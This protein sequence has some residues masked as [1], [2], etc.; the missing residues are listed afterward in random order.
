MRKILVIGYGFAVIT[1]LIIYLSSMP[2]NTIDEVYLSV[3]APFGMSWDELPETHS[4]VVE[5]DCPELI[6]SLGALLTAEQKD[7]ALLQCLN[8]DYSNL[9]LPRADI[10]A[11]FKEGDITMDL[12]GGKKPTQY[13][14]HF[15]HEWRPDKSGRKRKLRQARA[16]KIKAQLIQRYGLPNTNG[17]FDQSTQSG[18]VAGGKIE[19]PCSFWLIN[20]IGILLCSERVVMIDGIEMSLSFINFDKDLIG[21]DSRNRLLIAAGK[22]PEPYTPGSDL[23]NIAPPVKG[24]LKR[25]GKLVYSD[26]LN[27]CHKSGLEPI[28]D[29][30]TRTE[31][32]H[33]VFDDIYALYSGDELADYVFENSLA[34]QTIFPDLDPDIAIMLLLKQAAGQGS[35]SAMNEIG[36]ALLYCYQGIQQDIDGA[37]EWLNMAS[38]LGEPTAKHSL[39]RLHLAGLMGPESSKSEALTLIEQCSTI[40]PGDCAADARTLKEFLNK[41]TDF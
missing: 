30:W 32:F 11:A 38:E 22:M 20:N 14:Y 12:M 10:P 17:H 39:A 16:A 2:S 26:D 28:Q 7:E 35:A 19:Q 40:V 8:E 29:F 5:S 6:K 23:L 36:A 24:N 31:K 27:V 13:T 3:D 18:Y 41:Q 33:P 15:L 1:S 21:E 34:F 9:Y 4:S 37:I 25:L